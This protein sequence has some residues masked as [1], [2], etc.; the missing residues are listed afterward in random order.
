MLKE[1]EEEVLV[2]IRRDFR[3]KIEFSH[4]RTV[5]LAAAASGGGCLVSG[6]LSSTALVSL[7]CRWDTTGT[8]PEALKCGLNWSSPWNTPR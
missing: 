6:V 3:E 2:E 4:P 7:N 8:P 5:S 1:R